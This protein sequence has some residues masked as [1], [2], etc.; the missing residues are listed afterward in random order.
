MLELFYSSPAILIGP[1]KAESE[2]QTLLPQCRRSHPNLQAW[3]NL[4]LTPI[5]LAHSKTQT[6]PRM[7]TDGLRAQNK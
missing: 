3:S 1:Q 5:M 2:N 4:Y 7:R 6:T